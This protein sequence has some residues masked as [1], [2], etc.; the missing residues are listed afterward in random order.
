MGQRGEWKTRTG[1][2][3]AAL[4]SAIGLGNNLP[5]STIAE[6]AFNYHLVNYDTNGGVGA[7]GINFFSQFLC[8]NCEVSP[9]E[10]RPS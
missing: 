10:K 6:R 3:L 4:G 7:S 2:L 8:S 9:L 5:G 1:F